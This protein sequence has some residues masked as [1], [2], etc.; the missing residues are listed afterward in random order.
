MSLAISSH[1]DKNTYWFLKEQFLYYDL[2]DSFVSQYGEITHRTC[3]GIELANDNPHLHIHYVIKPTQDK[4]KTPYN[5]AQT[6][7]YHLG[8]SLKDKIPP[9][10]YSIKYC[11]VK[12]L[13]TSQEDFL[14]YVLKEVP[15][16]DRCLGIKEKELII[17]AAQAQEQYK[18][19][20]ADNAKKDEKKAN[21]EKAWLK[22]CEYMDAHDYN[23]IT[24]HNH[25]ESRLHA[26]IECIIQYKIDHCDG[27]GLCHT[28][29][30][31]A[32]RY[33]AKREYLDKNEI[34]KILFSR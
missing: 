7:K 22:M 19:K 15:D 21:E 8:K 25:Y 34:Y 10:S 30:G 13:K 32:I 33:L 2:L 14:R 3:S 6:L 28:I 27:K 4:K 1:F 17:M 12:D 11:K 16:F 26:C 24:D 31:Q 18:L 5:L 9:K 20:T 23:Y 29:K